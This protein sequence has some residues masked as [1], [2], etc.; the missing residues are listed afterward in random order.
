MEL[1]TLWATHMLLWLLLPL[2]LRPTIRGCLGPFACWWPA[3][4]TVASPHWT[5]TWWHGPHTSRRTCPPTSWWSV[6]ATYSQPTERWL[7]NQEWGFIKE[8]H[9]KARYS[10]SLLNSHQY[11]SIQNFLVSAAKLCMEHWLV[12]CRCSLATWLIIMHEK[13]TRFKSAMVFW[14]EKFPRMHN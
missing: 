6:T 9:I 14:L 4:Q 2:S 11:L 7:R 3:V 13:T 5:P 10:N 12:C 8:Y 1:L